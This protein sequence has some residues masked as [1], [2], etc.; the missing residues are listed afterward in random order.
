M[1]RRDD[2]IKV[3]RKVVGLRVRVFGGLEGKKKK[4]SKRKGRKEPA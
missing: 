2:A 4:E 3:K 1:E